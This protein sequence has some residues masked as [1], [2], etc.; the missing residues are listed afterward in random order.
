MAPRTA[1]AGTARRR[2]GGGG[3]APR[4]GSN[5]KAASANKIRR[6]KLRENLGVARIGARGIWQQAALC[7]TLASLISG[8]KHMYSL[9]IGSEA[10]PCA[11]NRRRWRGDVA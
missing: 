11:S 2:H 4:N 7:M 5:R 1:H 8:I 9:N 6:L 10:W 3:S